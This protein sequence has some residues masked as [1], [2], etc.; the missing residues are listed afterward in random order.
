MMA[1]KMK[2]LMVMIMGKLEQLIGAQGRKKMMLTVIKMLKIKIMM[3]MIVIRM[4]IMT[5][6]ML[7]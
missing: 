6:M 2:M 7:Y 5:R 1:I 4:M 3:M